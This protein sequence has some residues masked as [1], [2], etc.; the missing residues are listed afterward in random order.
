MSPITELVTY[1]NLNFGFGPQSFQ[2]C[3]LGEVGVVRI[4]IDVRNSPLG[5]FL[6]VSRILGRD[7]EIALHF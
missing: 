4:V 5:D 2:G 7:I 6:K 1:P 3:A